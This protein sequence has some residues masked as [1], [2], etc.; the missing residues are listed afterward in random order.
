MERMAVLHFKVMHWYLKLQDIY[1]V[2]LRK[3]GNYNHAYYKSH[4][5]SDI[6]KLT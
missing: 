1:A 6:D 3:Q 4:K 5:L 2:L